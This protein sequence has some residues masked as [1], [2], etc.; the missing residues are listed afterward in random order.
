MV[1]KMIFH[2]AKELN[3]VKGDHF[4]YF[5]FFSLSLRSREEA[6]TSQV[7]VE[8]NWKLSIIIHFP[9]TQHV[10]KH[11]HQAKGLN[12]RER[13]V[14]SYFEDALFSARML[15]PVIYPMLFLMDIK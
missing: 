1:I 8:C 5:P 13:R 4:L 6:K 11:H 2:P 9:L 10:Q 15:S 12:F 14:H 3:Y 7:P